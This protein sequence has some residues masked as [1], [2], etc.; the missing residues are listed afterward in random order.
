M[1]N[2]R[3]VSDN[4]IER[5]T[6]L[7]ASSRAGA[8]V[9][10]NLSNW[11]KSSF[12][13]AAGASERITALF[14]T[15][16]PIQFAGFAF[17]NWS[18]AAMMRVRVSEEDAATNLVR[19]STAL[20]NAA[21][22]K[23]GATVT[24][25]YGPAPDGSNTACRI[26]FAATGQSVSQ[27][28]SLGTGVLCSGSAWVKGIA[29]Q[30]ITITAG[31]VDQVI[32]INTTWRRLKAPGKNSVSNVFAISTNGGATARD[33]QVW[34]PQLETGAVCTSSYP[35]GATA[36]TRPAGYID[37]WQSYDYDSGWVPACPWPAA[38]LR[39]YTAAQAACAYAYGGGTYARHWLSAE[40]QARGLA[41]DIVDPDNVQGYLEAACMVAGPY[42][43]PRYNA[44]AASVTVLD[45]S[46][47]FQTGGGDTCGEVGFISDEISIDLSYFEEADRA[48]LKAMANNSAV[49]PLLL[50]VF[51]DD[52]APARERDHMI[53]ATR[54]KSS[55][56][57]TKYAA[58]Y[59][60]S[61]TFKEV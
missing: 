28:T 52:P 34:C 37:G 49:Y 57:G 29:N 9:E 56:I 47:N 14:A 23:T 58:G 36:A 19:Y 26:L 27:V 18:P 33:I 61:I 43:S 13:R 30:T 32:G 35:T 45:G 42:W 46:E 20:N 11:K 7:V 54:S 4:A 2:L 39:G 15:P 25:N 21:W 38:R 24:A 41:V 8:L 53:Y 44:S 31:G 10:A 40:V 60:T 6:S 1:P 59:T 48:A 51:P 3:I 12:W 50:S 5:A 55:A 22:T 16:E 17:C